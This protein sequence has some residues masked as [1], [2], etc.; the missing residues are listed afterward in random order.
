MEDREINKKINDK[1]MLLGV[2]DGHGGEVVVDKSKE[3]LEKYIEE[4]VIKNKVD[5]F[6]KD[7]FQ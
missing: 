3:F 4:Q 6:D 1:V 5:K 7:F 2:L